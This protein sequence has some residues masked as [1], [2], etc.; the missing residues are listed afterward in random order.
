MLRKTLKFI[1]AIGVILLVVL[2][3]FRA[4]AFLFPVKVKEENKTCIVVQ[5]QFHQINSK[6]TF[7]LDP[8]WRATTDCGETYTY[9]REVKVGDTIRIK[10]LTLQNHDR[11]FKC[12]N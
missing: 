10:I 2:G 3:L 1:G 11:I 7:Q 5:V 12:S 8:E 6:S 4:K 9:R